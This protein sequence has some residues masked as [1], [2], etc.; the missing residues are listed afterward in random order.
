MFVCMIASFRLRYINVAYDLLC[1]FAFYLAAVPYCE[2]GVT[3]QR[4]FGTQHAILYLGAF[5][6]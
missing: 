2:L 3:L 4:R 5:L 1:V 6:H